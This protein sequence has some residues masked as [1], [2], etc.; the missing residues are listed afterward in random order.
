MLGISFS[1]I[2]LVYSLLLTTVFFG[3]K[4]YNSNENKMYSLLIIINLI[5]LAIAILCYFFMKNME[6]YSIM[7]I[8]FSKLYL[9]YLCTWITIFTL[10]VYLISSKEFRNKI[11]TY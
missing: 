3:K 6:V 10:Y 11:F 8:I 7:N 5:G 4:R 9:D 1:F 2:S